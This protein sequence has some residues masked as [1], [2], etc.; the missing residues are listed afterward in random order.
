MP[1]RD[2]R[3]CEI[4][5]AQTL[6]RERWWLPAEYELRGIINR[7][8]FGVVIEVASPSGEML[9]AKRVQLLAPPKNRSTNALSSHA[10]KLLRRTLREI[11]VL[12]RLQALRHPHLARLV[13]AWTDVA[14]AEEDSAR[15]RIPAVYLL[16]ERLHA[17]PFLHGPLLSASSPAP[18]PALK[19][20]GRLLGQAL[21]GLHALHTN[22][23]LHRDLKPQN[24]LVTA[25]GIVRIIDFGMVRPMLPIVRPPSDGRLSSAPAGLAPAADGLDEAAP[26]EEAPSPAESPSPPTRRYSSDAVTRQ[27]RAPELLIRTILEGSKGDQ[28]FAH[29]PAAAAAS[30]L[31]VEPTT[32]RPSTLLLAQD[33]AI[34]GAA[35]DM[36]CIGCIMGEMLVR[37][38]AHSS[39]TKGGSGSDGDGDDSNTSVVAPPALMTP[40]EKQTEGVPLAL[41]PLH[42]P[43]T[44]RQQRSTTTDATAAVAAD[45]GSLD[46]ALLQGA[47]TFGIADDN[48]DED[49]LDSCPNAHLA[50]VL[51]VT[52]VPSEVLVDWRDAASDAVATSDE[53]GCTDLAEFFHR[54]TPRPS[55]LAER[56]APLGD[57]SACDLLTKL[58]HVDPRE[59]ATC[60][61]ALRHPFIAA[62]WEPQQA[63]EV[64]D[65]EALLS[66]ADRRSINALSE[67]AEKCTDLR[68]LVR[69]IRAEAEACGPVVECN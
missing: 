18:A 59:R 44:R 57:P 61:E 33:E 60:T 58:L 3:F 17:H 15:K 7:G 12:R 51:R 20:V 30:S 8:S 10:A 43:T 13:D 46:S 45:C 11:M 40:T 31:V 28:P 23:L 6:L 42:T 9:A 47:A 56:F 65:E 67:E 37:A 66:A 29:A 53:I 16:F 38:L 25:E 34:A 41:F 39:R 1:S 27:Y 4:D 32:M 35:V 19:D 50:S 54:L 63:L 55:M 26:A 14:V 21:A 2:G 49:L 48:D 36:W 5:D 52:G 24:V 22:R 68:R 62:N 69:L 64:A